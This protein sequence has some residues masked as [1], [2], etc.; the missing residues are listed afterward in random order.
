MFYIVFCECVYYMYDNIFPIS[1]LFVWLLKV[2]LGFYK[3]SKTQK[4]CFKEIIH[5]MQ[6]LPI[7]FFFFWV[8]FQGENA[9]LVPT[10][11]V[12][13]H[14]GPK[15][16]FATNVVPKKRKLFLFWSLPSTH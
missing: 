11:W 4:K 5:A 2:W 13:S 12:N 3:A 6:T 16:N 7:G 14:F 15:I 9:L 1:S 10:F 8:K